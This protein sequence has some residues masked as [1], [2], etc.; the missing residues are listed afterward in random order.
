[1]RHFGGAFS[2]VIV[3]FSGAFALPTRG[4]QPHAIIQRYF[5]YFWYFFVCLLFAF[6]AQGGYKCIH[7]EVGHIEF[8]IFAH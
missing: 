2:L 5:A 1:M 6:H 3:R 7:R 8:C 4:V